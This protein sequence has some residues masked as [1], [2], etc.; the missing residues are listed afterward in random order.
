[1]KTPQKFL[2]TTALIVA[3]T[4]L[5]SEAQAQSSQLVYSQ[6]FNG[7]AAETIGMG[8]GDG[9]NIVDNHPS[10]NARVYDSTSWGTLPAGQEWRALWLTSMTPSTVSNFF[11]PVKNTGQSVSSF[12]ANFTTLINYIGGG[13]LADGFSINFGKFNNTTSAYGSEAGMYSSGDGKTGNVLSLSVYT[14]TGGNPRFELRYNGSTVATNNKD[15]YY[16]I[17][18]PAPAE[19]F[20]PLNFSY[21]SNGVDVTYFGESIFSNVVVAGYTPGVNDSFAFAAR[22]GAAYENL[23]IDDITVNTTVAPFAWSG[24]AGNWTTAGNWTNGAAPTTNDN[25]IIMSGAGGN[26]NNN[27]VTGIQGLVFS[28]ATSGSYNLSGNNLTVGADGITNNSTSAQTISSNLTLGASQTFSAAS[29]ALTFT[30]GINNGGNLLTISGAGNTTVSTVKI[31]GAGG[32][33]KTGNGTLSLNGANDYSGATTVSGGTLSAVTG[34]LGGTSGITVNGATLTAVDF[35]SGI[36]LSVNS[37]G[38]AT[39]S[40]TAGQSVGALSNAGTVNFNGG[41]GTVSVSTLSGAGSTSFGS[42]ATITGGISEGTVA[43]TGALNSAISGGAVTAGTLGQTTAANI[44]GGTAN[45]TG[46]ANVNTL[47]L[48]SLTAGGNATLAAMSGGSLTANGNATI[49]TLNGGA[50]AI[51]ATKTATISEGTSSGLVSGAGGLTK[52]G[53]SSL[54]LSG[55]ASLGGN[56]V[57]DSGTLVVNGV[58]TTSASTVTIQSA[59]TLKGDGVI[60]GDTFIYGTHAPGNSP[61]LQTFAN[62]LT[63]ANGS[64]VVLEIAANSISNRG[65]YFDA[66]DVQGNLSFEG[67]VDLTLILNSSGSAV[68]WANSLWDNDIYGQQGWK[69]FGVNGTITGLSNLRILSTGWLDSNGVSFATALPDSSFSLFAGADGVYL[70]YNNIP[71]PSTYGLLGVGALGLALF[72]R[73]R[74]KK[75]IN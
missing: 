52:T 45:I 1:M 9:S 23:F 7:V 53:N 49:T 18:N 67:T 72:A 33:T 36:G 58:N 34:A 38:S 48:G 16:N 64:S 26:V 71:E 14:Y 30:G 60:A 68:D 21:D 75:L 44:S 61:G 57:A 3:A 6:N 56:L 69:I 8:I 35:N 27:A 70:N 20:L 41:S 19:D 10:F 25:W 22:T 2:T 42:N 37:T 51:A 74:K 39:I 31:T 40:G 43:V 59:A 28:S 65:T 47:S 62:N 29:G 5:S 66:I 24:G 4:F 11:M 46:A 73:R 32:L 63:Y 54:T 13:T 55:G 12:S 17:K 50:L 15:P